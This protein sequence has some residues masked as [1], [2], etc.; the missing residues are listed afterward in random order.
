MALAYTVTSLADHK[1]YTG[2]RAVGDEFV[3]D[4]LIDVTSIVATG[5]IIPASALGLSSV[6]CVSITGCDN[7][8]A[9]LPSV[10]ISAAGAYESS[11]SFALMFTALDGTNATLSNDANGGSVRVRV[12]GNL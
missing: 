3:V 6:H 4:A 10:E 11:T 2:P 9:V 7:A 12:Y 8:N 1:G 5:S